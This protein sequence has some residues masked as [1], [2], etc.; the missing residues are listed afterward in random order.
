MKNRDDGILRDIGEERNAITAI[1][2]KESE[3]CTGHLLWYND[4]V[5]NILE[6]MITDERSGARPR[7]SYFND[8]NQQ[9]AKNEDE[10]Y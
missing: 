1:H 10:Y 7:K 3:A 8:I 6:E 4:F 9:R 5:T 2:E